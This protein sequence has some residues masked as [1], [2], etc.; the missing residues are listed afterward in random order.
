MTTRVRRLAAATVA[1]TAVA[2]PL[3]TATSAAP[4]SAAVP[5]QVYVSTGWQNYDGGCRAKTELYYWPAS[6]TV[7]MKTSVSDPYLFVACRV[8]AK[9]YFD[10]SVGP[11]SDGPTQRAM[12]CAVTDPTC[13]STTYGAWESFQPASGTLALLANYGLSPQQIVNSVR[14]GFSKA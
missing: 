2:V 1:A 14:V 3:A 5:S 7:Q 11:V 8:N 13:A 6:N 9:V 10:T 4:A 12:A